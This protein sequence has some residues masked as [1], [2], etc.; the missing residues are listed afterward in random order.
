[1]TDRVLETKGLNL[2]PSLVNPT[3]TPADDGK[4]AALALF[5]AYQA[6]LLVFKALYTMR[7]NNLDMMNAKDSLA[8][9][10]VTR[11]ASSEA[12]AEL[13]A[14]FLQVGLAFCLWTL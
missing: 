6:S 7:S 5:V 3:L 1:M 11:D 8:Y 9:D 2:V 14:K 4:W 12:A 10:P 13:V